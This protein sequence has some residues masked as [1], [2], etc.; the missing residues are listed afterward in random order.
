MFLAASNGLMF[1]LMPM[2]SA[3]SITSSSSSLI[4]SII[5][6]ASAIKDACCDSG[7]SRRASRPSFSCNMM[8]ISSGARDGPHGVMMALG[9]SI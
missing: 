2:S 1:S 8:S 3:T 4:W 7:T 9:F 5:M 6:S